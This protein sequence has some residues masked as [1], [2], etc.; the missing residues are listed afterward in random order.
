MLK[1]EDRA[2]TAQISLAKRNNINVAQ[3]AAQAARQILGGVGITGD[4]PI[5]RHLMNLESVSTYEGTNDVHLL[6]LGAYITGIPAYK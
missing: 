3:R 2:T 5:M 4:Y 1:N 6:I